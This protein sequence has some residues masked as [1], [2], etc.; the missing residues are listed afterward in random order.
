MR[1]SNKEANLVSQ[2]IS[3]KFGLKFDFETNSS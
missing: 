3:H 1:S 2:Q